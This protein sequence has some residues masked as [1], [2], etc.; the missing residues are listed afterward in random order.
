MA[1]LNLR[2]ELFD[3]S[4]FRFWGELILGLF[5]TIVGTIL[6]LFITMVENATPFEGVVLGLLT[7]NLVYLVAFSFKVKHDLTWKIGEVYADVRRVLGPFSWNQY[8]ERATHFADEKQ[9]L[10][11]RLVTEQLPDLIKECWQDYDERNRKSPERID[12]I[13]DSGTTLT[14]AFAAL[15]HFGLRFEAK[16]QLIKSAEARQHSVRDAPN[17]DP[18]FVVHT[19]SMSGVGEFNRMGESLF[20][21]ET[22]LELFGGNPL[23]RYQATTGKVTESA[24]RMVNPERTGFVISVLTANWVLIGNTFHTIHL[25]A[26]GRGH[27]EFKAAAAANADCV[28]VVAPLGKLLRTDDVNVLNGLDGV[29]GEYASIPLADVVGDRCRTYLLTTYRTDRAELLYDHTEQ[30]LQFAGTPGPAKPDFTFRGVGPTPGGRAEILDKRLR[31]NAGGQ[32][33]LNRARELPHQYILDARRLLTLRDDVEVIPKRSLFA[34][35][36]R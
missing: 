3:E 4:G 36:R 20:F 32:P 31:F 22:N 5:T 33:R 9:L 21:S 28:V 13:I 7:A 16:E 10:C 15:K 30:L 11:E 26:R 19:N 1:N 14:P 2:K 35:W 29:H 24:A 18:P 6:G 17:F 25:C 27:L 8:Q 12:I 34:S 23:G